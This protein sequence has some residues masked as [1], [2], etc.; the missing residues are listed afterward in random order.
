MTIPRGSI[1]RMHQ[2]GAGPIDMPPPG[3]QRLRLRLGSR[4]ID[5]INEGRW[6]LEDRIETSRAEL[7]AKM[8]FPMP[9]VALHHDAMID[10]NAY[11][12]DVRETDYAGGQVYTDRL[13]AFDVH[14]RLP[15]NVGETARDPVFGLACR[16][17]D[18]A[19]RQFILNSSGTVA[20]PD[21]VIVTH[22]AEV[23]RGEMST[24]LGWAEIEIML[25]GLDAAER[26]PLTLI[27]DQQGRVAIQRVIK[28][29]LA[30]R[31]PVR[32]LALVVESTVDGL[33]EGLSGARLL[34]RVRQALALTISGSLAGADGHIAVLT[35]APEW[36]GAFS[37]RD[38]VGTFVD[39]LRQ[40]LK[41]YEPQGMQPALLAPPAI[42]ATVRAAGARVAPWI[43]VLSPREV[44]PRFRLRVLGEVS[45]GA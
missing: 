1:I 18:P 4:L 42:R 14:G 44:H 34:D 5:A 27:G 11:R 17:V 7:A 16:W 12:I 23:V 39:T 15:A 26:A 43:S 36:E 37:V 24:L 33:T 9:D 20:E 30:E 32:D 6:R 29:L 25:A 31:V 41:V 22:L 35:I 10:A 8:G 21:S 13:L 28:G 2:E 38:S 40:V 45:H 3:F 19:A